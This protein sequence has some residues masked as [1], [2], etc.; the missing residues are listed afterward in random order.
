MPQ[1]IVSTVGMTLFQIGDVVT[2]AERAL[3]GR[4]ANDYTP[5][6]ALLDLL[7]NVDNDPRYQNM[8]I[9]NTAE[10]DTLALYRRRL[11]PDLTDW[12]L[13]GVRYGFIGTDTFPSKMV[14]SVFNR[15]L[16]A[17]Y[18]GVSRCNDIVVRG[19][20]VG[21]AIGLDAALREL[22]AVL[23]RLTEPYNASDVL[24]NISG[25]FKFVSGWMAAYAVHRGFATVYTFEG[26]KEMIL[27]EPQYPGDFPPRLSYI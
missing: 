10:F 2:P 21:S 17:N 14:L 27:T 13:P 6:Q 3:L 23:D 24:F 11:Q 16:N 7:E 1:L 26:S 12:Y 8:S 22:Y 19:L 25:G 9:L 20:Q 18:T 15:F 4:H 5:P